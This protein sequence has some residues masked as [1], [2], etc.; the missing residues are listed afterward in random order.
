MRIAGTAQLTAGTRTLDAQALRISPACQTPLLAGQPWFGGA[1]SASAAATVASGGPEID[2]VMWDAYLNGAFHP[3]ILAQ[4]E[5]VILRLL[6]AG[7]ATGTFAVK[8]NLD[9]MEVAAY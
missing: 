3:I 6:S 7:P 9:W 4:N 5:G 2:M 8:V 1:I